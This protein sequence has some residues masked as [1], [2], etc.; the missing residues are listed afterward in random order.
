MSVSDEVC[1]AQAQEEF[2][3]YETTKIPKDSFVNAVSRE[4]SINIIMA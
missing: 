2:E 4:R 1:D 3:Y